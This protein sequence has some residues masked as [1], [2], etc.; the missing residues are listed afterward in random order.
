MP[1]CLPGGGGRG[2]NSGLHA[3]PANTFPTEPSVQALTEQICLSVLWGP[4]S[5]FLS[6]IRPSSVQGQTLWHWGPPEAQIQ[7]QAEIITA[8]IRSK[9]VIHMKR[10]QDGEE[11]GDTFW[12]EGPL[13]HS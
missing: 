2:L 6:I 11:G 7:Q 5:L 3:C 8:E 4:L 9:F 10:C 13:C 1:G 12:L